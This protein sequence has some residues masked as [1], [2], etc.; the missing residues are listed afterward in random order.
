MKTDSKKA[1]RHGEILFVE[2]DNIPTNLT[3]HKTNTLLTGSGN[4]P[5]TF[6][7]GT[8][9]QVDAP[10]DYIFGYFKANN[11]KLYHKEHGDKSVRGLLEAELPNGIYELRRQVE[12]TPAG[13][14]PVID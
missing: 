14:R 4:N 3:E 5:H 6:I 9:Y 8:Y 13:L 10:D 1:F 2:T 7:G 11:T 12:F